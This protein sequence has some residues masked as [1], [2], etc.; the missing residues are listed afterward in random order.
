M[1]VGNPDVSRLGLRRIEMHLLEDPDA[2]PVFQ[3]LRAFVALG[4]IEITDAGPRRK[5]LQIADARL[6]LRL[7]TERHLLRLAGLDMTLGEIEVSARIMEQEVEPP[8][9]LHAENDRA[10]GDFPDD[11][12][13]EKFQ[14]IIYWLDDRQKHKKS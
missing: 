14:D 2:A 12:A 1:L 9:V 6:L 5:Y 10:H 13:A 4:D 11:R 3:T 8:A 7:A